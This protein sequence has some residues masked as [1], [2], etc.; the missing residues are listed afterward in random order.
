MKTED[1]EEGFQEAVT[2]NLDLEISTSF[3]WEKKKGNLGPRPEEVKTWSRECAGYICE[4][5]S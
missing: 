1:V 3:L 5:M 4:E 2:L